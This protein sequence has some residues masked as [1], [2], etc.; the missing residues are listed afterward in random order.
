MDKRASVCV[1]E[2]IRMMYTR[3]PISTVEGFPQLAYRYTYTRSVHFASGDSKLIMISSIHKFSSRC[4]HL[5]VNTSRRS[6]Q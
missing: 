2:I 6:S 1:K 4:M 5:H 3:Q